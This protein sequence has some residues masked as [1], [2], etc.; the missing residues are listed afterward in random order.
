MSVNPFSKNAPRLKY[1]DRVVLWQAC[2]LVL[3]NLAQQLHHPSGIGDPAHVYG[4][5]HIG[6]VALL[7]RH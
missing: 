7:P 5:G 3:I 4:T 2:P 1:A 6:L